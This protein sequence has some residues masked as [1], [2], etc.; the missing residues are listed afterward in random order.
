MFSGYILGA[1]D[2]IIINQLSS[3]IEAGKYAIV[4]QLGSIMSVIILGMNN[5]WV[6]MFYEKLNQ[7][8]FVE[9]FPVLNKYICIITT[10]GIFLVLFLNNIAKL[11]ISYTF[12]EAL[13][14]TP[15]LVLGYFFI[16]STQSLP[17]CPLDYKKN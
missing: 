6:P 8:K 5:A 7:D 12:Y 2:Q 15:I 14:L 4:F 13:T 9:L 10:I 17:C 16:F 11:F 1:F 3:E